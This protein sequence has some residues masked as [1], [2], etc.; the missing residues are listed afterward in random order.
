MDRLRV[1]RPSMYV[2]MY[3]CVY[4]C[5]YVCMYASMVDSE[6][7]ARRH[8]HVDACTERD[9]HTYTYIYRGTAAAR[10][11]PR[12]NRLGGMA[13]CGRRQ[14]LTPLASA[15]AAEADPVDDGEDRSCPTM[16]A[17]DIDPSA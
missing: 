9:K 4:V 10:A 8:A 12:G 14:W 13:G 15:A 1:S 5:M 3:V 11:T 2:C 17:A 16:S 6:G 7:D